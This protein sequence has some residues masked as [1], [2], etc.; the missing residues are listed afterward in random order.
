MHRCAFWCLQSPEE[1]VRFPETGV[2]D[3]FVSCHIGTRNWATSLVLNQLM[4][5]VFIEY[6]LIIF[7]PLSS[8][9]PDPPHIPP[10]PTSC[11]LSLLKNKQ[12]KKT[13]IRQ[14]IPK[15]NKV[16]KSIKKL[17]VLCVGLLVLECGWLIYP[18]TLYWGAG[19]AF[20]SPS[21]Y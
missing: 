1:C 9:L 20:S 16:L 19:T 3:S 4:I 5:N 11:S 13:P 12:T 7:L 17:S 18:T 15:Q 14:K 10:S 6:I 8:P 21:R 2:Q